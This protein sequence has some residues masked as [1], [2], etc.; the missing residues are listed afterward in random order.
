MNCKLKI[1]NDK[2]KKLQP[3]LYSKLV[4]IKKVA[5]ADNFLKF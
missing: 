3:L 5:I 2:G 4:Q 1:T